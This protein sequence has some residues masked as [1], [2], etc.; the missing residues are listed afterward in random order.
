MVKVDEKMMKYLTKLENQL[1]QHCTIIAERRK[2]REDKLCG[3][4]YD[5][6][7]TCQL[8][9]VH[10]LCE[11]CFGECEACPFCRT[12]YCMCLQIRNDKE[13]F[14]LDFFSFEM[15]WNSLPMTLHLIHGLVVRCMDRHDDKNFILM[16]CTQLNFLVGCY[17]FYREK[18]GNKITYKVNED[19]VP[20]IDH[21]LDLKWDKESPK[22]RKLLIQGVHGFID[23]L[24]D[25]LL[26]YN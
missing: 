17:I 5:S 24:R 21:F 2:G 12:K 22:D 10:K 23:A 18:K 19:I 16:S 1:T 13:I 4:C 25:I 7:A 11:T 3:V 8:N 14:N 15:G 26:S 9:C 20:N 6:E